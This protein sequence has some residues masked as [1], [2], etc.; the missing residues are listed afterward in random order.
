MAKCVAC[1]NKGL[2]MKV[3][4]LGLCKTCGPEVTADIEKHSEVIYSEMHIY[5]RAKSHDE[6]LAAIDKLLASAETLVG[7]EEKGLETCSP[8]ARLVLDEYRGFRQELV[9]GNG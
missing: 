9:G 5:E 4:K 6:K 8:P 7:Y 3:D 1:G 2:L